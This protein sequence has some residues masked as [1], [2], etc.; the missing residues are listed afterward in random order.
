VPEHCRKEWSYFET[1]DFKSGVVQIMND[2][3]LVTV[4]TEALASEMA[5]FTNTR[6]QVIKNCVDLG[7]A[8]WCLRRPFKKKQGIT[9]AWHGSFVHT[10]DVPV[11]K[12]A[13]VEVMKQREC[14]NL[15]LHGH[16]THELFSDELRQFGNRVTIDGW[17]DHSI[18]YYGLRMY[19][20][21]ISPLASHEFNR[22]KSNVKWLEYAASEIPC[23][24]TPMDPYNMCKNGEDIIFAESRED[25]TNRLIELVDNFDYR[26]RIGLSARVRAGREFDNKIVSEEWMKVFNRVL[27]KKD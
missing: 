12:D 23:V 8:D 26:R 15:A 24:A 7:H 3:D 4:S 21:G 13:L 11:V 18:L 9:I 17:I 20:I 22:C 6:I 25:W 10:G 2:S 19:D 14:V 5:K 16:F 1:P 27:G